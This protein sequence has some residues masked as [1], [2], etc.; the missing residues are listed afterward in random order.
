[1]NESE[2]EKSERDEKVKINHDLLNTTL[3]SWFMP[4]TTGNLIDARQ[5]K[6]Q[7]G[8]DKTPLVIYLGDGK[9]TGSD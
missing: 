8:K 2:N 7:K 4:G 5:K 3:N 9:K 1:M 6:S